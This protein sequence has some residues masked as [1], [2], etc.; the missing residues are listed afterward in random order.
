MILMS[1]DASGSGP[2]NTIQTL[3]VRSSP[4]DDVASARVKVGAV[5]AV[6]GAITIV[7][8][9]VGLWKGWW[10]PEVRSTYG[11]ARGSRISLGEYSAL[12]A[13]DFV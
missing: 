8:A 7:I 3:Q 6:V 1:D 10:K 12:G 2:S 11:V 13:L 5:L 9:Y 4:V